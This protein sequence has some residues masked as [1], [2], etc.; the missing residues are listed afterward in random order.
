[1]TILSE[2]RNLANP[3]STK[4]NRHTVENDQQTALIKRINRRYAKRDCDRKVRIVN[5]KPTLIDTVTGLA[6]PYF[7][8]DLSDL[9][10]ILQLAN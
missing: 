6:R 5:G 8:R 1:M 10:N 9:W 3:E 7:F 2:L 4:R